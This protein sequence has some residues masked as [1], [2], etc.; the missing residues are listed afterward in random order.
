MPTATLKAGAR[1]GRHADHGHRAGAAG[2][3]IDL[4]SR[5]TERRH[6]LDRSPAQRVR[7]LWRTGRLVRLRHDF[8]RAR[9]RARVGAGAL[10]LHPVHPRAHALAQAHAASSSGPAG[11]CWSA[12]RC[13]CRHFS[14][15][16]FT[17]CITPRRIT[18]P[19]R[20][21]NT[22][23]WPGAG[24]ATLR[25]MVPIAAAEPLLLVL[26]FLFVMPV[27]ALIPAI[28]RVR[29]GAYERHGDEPALRAHRT[30]AVPHLV[31]RAR[32]GD[33][34]LRLDDLHPGSRRRRSRS[35]W[36]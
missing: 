7:R 11:M 17:I 22:C 32:S 27:A 9:G 31:A 3:S 15:K 26:R 25:L 6:L 5:Q 20:T 14:T 13:C 2:V 1:A 23:N 12:F 29:A 21:P 18:A 36:C 8:H 10:S 4:G 34:D 24:G 28:A 33:H 19:R 30:A 35:S 16:A